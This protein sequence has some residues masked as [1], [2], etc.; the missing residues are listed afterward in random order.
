MRLGLRELRRRPRAFVVPTATLWLLALLLLYP[1]A[2]LDGLYDASTG[3][4][5]ELEGDLVV[6]SQDA[7]RSVFR[8]RLDGATR[9]ALSAVPGVAAVTGFDAAVL[10]ARTAGDQPAFGVAVI[11]IERRA[12]EAAGPPPGQALAD[13]SLAERGVTAGSV[14]TVGPVPTPVTVAGTVRGQRL[15]LQGALVLDTATWHDVVARAAPGAGLAADVDQ[16]LVV[17]LAPGADA[18]VVAD[19]LATATG[20]ATEALTID[21]VIASL[22]GIEQQDVTFGLLRSATLGVAAIVVGLFLSFLTLE[23]H[24]LLAVLK[25]VGASSTQLVGGVLAQTVAITAAAV[26]A[27]VAV[28]VVLTVAV[29]LDLPTSLRASRVAETAIGL[30]VTAV[31]GASLALR[32]VVAVDPASAIA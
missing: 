28:T 10:N 19:A 16:A 11:G 13:A 24:P 23:R 9:V 4:L 31:V 3:V 22:P 7:H 17:H 25:A 12:P 8:S 2:V 27:A 15:L 32:R 20:G 29:P 21:E 5:H 30:A 26:T 14:V 18:E 6:I 1:S